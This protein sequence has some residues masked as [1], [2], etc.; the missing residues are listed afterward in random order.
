MNKI[1]NIL[2]FML[3]FIYIGCSSGGGVVGDALD[4]DE[5]NT[6]INTTTSSV[7]TIDTSNMSKPILTIKNSNAIQISELNILVGESQNIAIFSEA[8]NDS[9]II[10]FNTTPTA[11]NCAEIS[12][13]AFDLNKTTIN[14]IVK[15]TGVEECSFIFNVDIEDTYGL[16]SSKSLNIK[17]AKETTTHNLNIKDENGNYLVHNNINLPLKLI[18]GES[19]NIAV[20]TDAGN[21]NSKII[22]FET[23]PTITSCADIAIDPFDLDKQI[24]NP[25]IKFT[26]KEECNFNFNIKIEDNNGLK[27]DIELE[28][29]VGNYNDTYKNP[30]IEI[31]DENY[32]DIKDKI[33]NLTYNEMKNIYISSKAN[34]LIDD[35]SKIVAF[36][37]IASSNTCA[38]ITVDSFELNKEIINPIIKFTAGTEDCSF[39]LNI[40]VENDH[41]LKTIEKVTVIVDKYKTFTSAT[42]P[43]NPI[44]KINDNTN[45]TPLNLVVG[46]YINIATF[47]DAN[48]ID[49]KIISVETSP[50]TPTC[51]DIA[52]DPFELDNK[53]INPVIKFTAKEECDFIFNI[54]VENDY[55]MKEIS[56]LP[57]SVRKYKTDTF[58]ITHEHPILTI[59]DKLNTTITNLNLAI[60]DSK[61]ISFYSEAK[62]I[63]DND[64]KIID[65]K[66]IATDPNNQCVTINQDSITLNQYIVNPIIKFT[67]LEECSFIFNVIAENNYGLKAIESIPVI[68]QKPS[69]TITV[70]NSSVLLYEGEIETINF[71]VKD[72]NGDII[73]PKI[74]LATANQ[75]IAV[76]L[77]NKLPLN[78]KINI[79]GLEKGNTDITIYALDDNDDILGSTTITATVNTPTVSNIYPEITISD[80]NGTNLDMNNGVTLNVGD[81][82]YI[83]VDADV[84]AYNPN[85]N[86][87]N[88]IT[89]FYTI[90]SAVIPNGCVDILIDES[91]ELNKYSAITAFI[92]FTGKVDC[93]FDF[94]VIVKDKYDL[95]SSQKFNIDVN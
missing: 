93:N 87:N 92:T 24:I 59:K 41:G 39:D 27:S 6:N 3:I 61:N 44:V 13:D 17:I 28:V 68:V 67:G 42:I 48:N 38:E 32:E 55:G 34:N 79:A 63:L 12:M 50:T 7:S 4:G 26:G 5:S 22:S 49:S 89:N 86:K 8:V 29:D 10:S 69:A 45:P 51:V 35:D 33:I 31:K 78:N 90:P 91:L 80:E 66:I 71:E 64:S 16:K 70:D 2:Y 65:F 94:I 23:T 11:T 40:E 62:N 56:Q 57:V 77:V 73:D 76:P 84:Q 18:I 19:Q 25:I 52:I 88:L 75:D 58:G 81:S 30:L 53:I 74:T 54:E 36:N 46:D 43:N 1:K 85:T 72:Q 14:P 37:P 21:L 83:S 20:F 47:I 95:V 82:R 15:F 9:R 60:G